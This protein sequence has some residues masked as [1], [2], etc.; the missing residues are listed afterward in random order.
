M[1]GDDNECF[2]YGTGGN[3]NPDCP[4]FQRGKCEEPQEMDD[5][6]TDYESYMRFIDA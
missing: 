3:C 2:V 6:I 4:V 5:S 1:K